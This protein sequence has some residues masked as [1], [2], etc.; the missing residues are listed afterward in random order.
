MRRLLARRDARLYLGGQALSLFGDTAMWLALGIWAKQ[1]TGSS[2]AAG[3]VIFALALPQLAAPAAGMLVD[4]VRRRP[5]L[6]A[7]NLATAAAVLPLLAVHDRDQL[8][9]IYAVAAAYGASYSILGAGQTAL[10]G[11]I[12]PES[13]LA[14]ANGAL[15]TLREAQRLIAPLAGAGLFSALGGGAVALIDAATFLA[16]AAAL[17]AMH[18]DEPPP[19][20]RESHPLAEALAG[21]RHLR[22]TVALRQMVL[23]CAVCLVGLGFSETLVY[24]IT[25]A[26]LH[27]SPSFVGVLMATQGVGA[28]V[29]AVNAA[30]VARRT[31]EGILAGLG[32]AA[33][34]AG[35]LLMTSG[36]LAVVLA[37]KVVFGAGAAWIIVGAITLLQRL[38]PGPLQG[39]AYSAVELLV[40]APQTLSIAAGAA[41]VTVVDYRWLLLAEATLLA[42][43]ATYLLTRRE[44]RVA[45]TPPAASGAPSAPRA[46]ARPSGTPSPPASGGARRARS[47]RSAMSGARGRSG[48]ARSAAPAP[49]RSY[50]G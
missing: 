43:C 20:P 42:A 29:G 8:W 17:V 22:A 36:A 33:V 11:S 45:S 10:L 2:G 14:E 40:G 27:R 49:R 31:S 25:D 38:T 35:A 19:A 6:I 7:T 5:L 34:A 41:L 12:L 44:Q 24:A 13:L 39:R 23:A 18:V 9:L 50:A 16:A 48:A 3:M 47:G 28:V 37:G 15:Q 26:G 21:A 1:L 4:R 30:R 46:P 32:M